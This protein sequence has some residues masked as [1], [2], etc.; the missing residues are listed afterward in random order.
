MLALYG[1]LGH[2]GYCSTSGGLSSPIDSEGFTAEQKRVMQQAAM[3]KLGDPEPLLSST[4]G[5]IKVKGDISVSAGT[6]SKAAIIV[7]KNSTDI[8]IEKAEVSA[9][10]KSKAVAILNKSGGMNSDIKAEN[11]S[12]KATG[13]S[14]AYG[15]V[16]DASDW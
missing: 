11:I 13:N 12:V 16:D 5:H 3:A 7:G 10:E 2:A 15:F 8:E 1:G 6:D 14:Q 4:T 9:E